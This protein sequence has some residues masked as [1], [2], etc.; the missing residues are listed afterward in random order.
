MKLKKILETTKD[1]LLNIIA[2][3]LSTGCMQLVLYPA[4]AKQ[5]SAADYGEMLTVMGVFNVVL[6]AFGNNLSYSRLLQEKNYVQQGQ[7]GE[8]SAHRGLPHFKKGAA[9][10]QAAPLGSSEW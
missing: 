3:L 5:M 8:N 2:A 7:K 1:F 10:M 4:L 9:V 6:L